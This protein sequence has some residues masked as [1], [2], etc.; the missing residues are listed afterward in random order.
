M[1]GPWLLLTGEEGGSQRIAL[2]S[3]D[4]L[5]AGFTEGQTTV[6]YQTVLWPAGEKP[7][8]L[9]PVREEW[10][11]YAVFVRTLAATRG[12]GAIK[13]GDSMISAALPPLLMALVFLGALGTS[14]YALADE[15]TTL[16]W[17]L[18]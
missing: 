16:R 15:P 14:I 3:I 17:C 10:P 13:R 2:A 8:S 11:A 1:D 18:P 6:F 7:I 12:M 9:A 5:R 4:R